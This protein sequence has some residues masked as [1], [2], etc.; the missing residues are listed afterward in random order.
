M[1]QT[2]T[3]I[4]LLNFTFLFAQEV[5]PLYIY[6]KTDGSLPYLEYGQGQDRLGG[7]KM[8]FLDTAITMQV[9]DSIGSRYMVRLSQNHEAFIPKSNLKFVYNYSPKAYYL[10]ESWSVYGDNAFDYVR[11]GL[12]ARLPYRSIQQINPSRIVVDIFGA[13]NN[14]NW[15]TQL[16]SAKEIKNVFHE[17]I[18]DDVF[19][20]VI[21]L[22]HSQHWGYSISYVNNSLV[23]RVKR[24][25]D[26]LRIKDIKI[27][28]DAGHGGSA[29]GAVGGTMGIQEKD[30]ALIFAKELEKL[31]NKKGAKT[32]MTRSEDVDVQMTDR[33]KMLQ[34]EDPTLLISLHLNSSSNKN[35]KGTST[36]YRH[37]GFRPLTESIL[38]RMLDLN[39][40]EFGNIG[41]F[42]FSLSG[43][44]EY[45]NC[46]VEIAFVS[47][48]EDEKRIMD[49]KFHKQVAKQVYKGIKDWLKENR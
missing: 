37:I 3:F 46:L 40:N 38:K 22:K 49:P 5:P 4:L 7:A 11:I 41:S 8:T 36:Y 30:Y 19:R 2:L 1:K 45:P 15:I 35:A 26:R 25:P 48:E 44:T 33:I 14:T 28:I 23:V 16:R 42:N 34:E 24:Q 21:E 39:L 43:P 20:V 17:Q 47:N 10:T 9:L 6:G 18:E 12:P 29:I 27:A 32:F 31:L 13:V